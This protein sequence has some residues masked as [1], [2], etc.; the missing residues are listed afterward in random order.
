MRRSF[1][2][3]QLAPQTTHSPEPRRLRQSRCLP[4]AAEGHRARPPGKT[5]PAYGSQVQWED[6]PEH[7]HGGHPAARARLPWPLG[8]CCWQDFPPYT[9]G[10]EAA[11]IQLQTVVSFIVTTPKG[12]CT[13][14]QSEDMD[15]VPSLT[16]CEL[17]ASYPLHFLWCWRNPKAQTQNWW[18]SSSNTYEVP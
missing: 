10:G 16:S 7:A 9:P 2:Y 3:I 14:S 4:S 8:D 12:R 11:G 18:A 15:S 13:T 1:P 6:F 5:A 17:L